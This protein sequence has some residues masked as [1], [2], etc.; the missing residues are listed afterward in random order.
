MT[1]KKTQEFNH[2]NKILKR[3]RIYYKSQMTAASF[4]SRS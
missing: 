3:T 4:A 2:I 1:E